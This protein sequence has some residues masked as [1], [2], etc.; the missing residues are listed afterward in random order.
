MATVYVRKGSKNSMRR[1]RAKGRYRIE[2][3]YDGHRF[4]FSL[5]ACGKDRA[6]AFKSN[7][8]DLLDSRNLNCK[9]DKDTKL[10][11]K[12]L[13]KETLAFL[14]DAGLSGDATRNL[15][16]EAHIDEMLRTKR[17]LPASKAACKPA[18]DSLKQY[19]GNDRQLHT[20]S[21]TDANE[22]WSA[23]EDQRLGKPPLA[24]ATRIKR[25]NYCKAV[26]NAAVKSRKIDE[27]PFANI[28]EPGSQVNQA[29][30]HYYELA[31][32]EAVLRSDAISL[33][34]KSLVALARF[35]G[36]R[37]PS[38]ASALRWADIDFEKKRLVVYNAKLGSGGRKGPYRTT[39]LRRRLEEVLRELR[40]AS[41]NHDGLVFG[42]PMAR[43]L[44]NPWRRLKNALELLGIESSKKP[45]QNLRGSYVTELRRAGL[46]RVQVAKWSG[47]SVEVADKH[48]DFETSS[49][50]LSAVNLDDTCGPFAGG[51][52]AA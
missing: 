14:A 5:G 24:V 16:L 52:L 35:A 36:L 6:Y 22:Y 23:I 13:P 18:H 7:L 26:F 39:P 21:E 10:W 12:G 9:L 46:S 37:C 31:E 28:T 15:T 41:P 30:W 38:E 42:G 25:L 29:R 43:I 48:Y 20:I 33:E 44:K 11:L 50:F 1:K 2:F 4:C 19:F 51:R 40:N 17:R 49:D 8:E 3:R 45:W 34:L 27:N 47:H 32:V